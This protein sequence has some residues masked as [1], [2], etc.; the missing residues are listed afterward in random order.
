MNKEISVIK[1]NVDKICIN[2]RTFYIVGT[3]HVSHASVELAESTIEELNP[4]AVAVELCQSRF[5]SLKNPDRW[6]NTDIVK[7]LKEG[8]ALLL[9]FQLVL[10]GYQKRLGDKLNIKPGAEMMAAV[11]KAESKNIPIILIDREVRTTLRR[12]WA[13]LSFFTLIKLFLSSLVES[14]LSIF[15]KTDAKSIEE[16]IESLKNPNALETMMNEFSQALPDVKEPLIDE[17]DKYLAEK[18][19]SSPYNNIVAI[20]GAG[21]VPGIK[22]LIGEKIDLESLNKIPPTSL[23]SKLLSIIFPALL[24][25]FLL[26]GFFTG[27]SEKTIELAGYWALYT[28]GSAAIGA[29]LAL[30]HPFSII[31]AAIAAPITTI[32]PLLAAGWISGIVEALI[33]KPTV[34]DVE[35]ILDD[36]GSIKGIWSNR[37]ARVFLVMILTNLTTSIGMIIGTKVIA[38]SL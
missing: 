5:D 10:A 13:S 37:L 17:R 14:F 15:R 8:K 29:L 11:K 4:D 33:R 34:K 27:G 30:A 6:R 18:I 19:Y 3:A 12:A 32:H 36:I 26:A 31:S 23:S 20:V 21:H 25:V 9:L 35:S 24:L 22:K 38:F 7:V 28:G 1:D 16:E 2:G